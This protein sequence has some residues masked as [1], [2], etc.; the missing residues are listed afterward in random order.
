MEMLNHKLI[1]ASNINAISRAYAPWL[2]PP[3]FTGIDLVIERLAIGLGV[4][5]CFK[6]PQR[7]EGSPS[8]WTWFI[9][10]NS[11]SAILSFS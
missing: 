4:F 5:G 3:A 7:W 10:W 11:S 9:H 2:R 1:E 8:L 6:F